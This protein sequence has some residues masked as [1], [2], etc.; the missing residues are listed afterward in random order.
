MSNNNLKPEEQH[1]Q[2]MQRCLALARLARGCT[3]PNPLVGSVIVQDGEIVGSGFHPQAGQPHA[4]IFALGA[5]GAKA[6][7]ATLYV[8]LE[9]CNHYGRTPPCTEAIIAAGIKTVVIGMIDPDPRVSGAGVK[10]LE[11]AGIS[12]IVGIE[13]AAARQLN[14]AFCHRVLYHRPLGILK[15]AMTLD[16]KI[17]TSTGDSAWVSSDNS[18]RFVHQ[19][20]SEVDAVVVGGQ[21]VRQDNPYLTT[22][23]LTPHN[24]LRVVMSR[25]LD[26]PPHSHLWQTSEAKTLV[27]TGMQAPNSKIEKLL[28]LGVEV[29]Q[30]PELTPKEVMLSLYERGMSA[31]LWECGGQLAAQ[32][33]ASGMIQ[34]VVAFIAPKIVG[35]VH[36][37]SP[38]GDLGINSMGKALLLERVTVQYIEPDMLMEGYLKLNL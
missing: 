11:E 29:L 13:E 33:I 12:T 1:W 17:A 10:R 38:V 6:R 31:V 30:F 34:K 9:P 4:E 36:A 18:R 5:A 24:P 27:F 2:M 32:A 16:G 26:L 22:H 8:N 14:E 28:A 25:S 15:Y 20:R 23:G 21:T 35:G 37:P 3:A 7:G 19:L